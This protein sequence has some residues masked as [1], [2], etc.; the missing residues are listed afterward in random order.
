MIEDEQDPK[1]IWGKI[2]EFRNQTRETNPL[3]VRH[4]MYEAKM[5]SSSAQLFVNQVLSMRSEILRFGGVVSNHEVITIL[6]GGVPHTQVT[7]NFHFTVSKVKTKMLKKSPTDCTLCYV[8]KA[9]L[10]LDSEIQSTFKMKDDASSAQALVNVCAPSNGPN[11]CW[12]CHQQEHFQNQCAEYQEHLLQLVEK[13]REGVAKLN[14]TTSNNVR[15][16]SKSD[17]V[18]LNS[19]TTHSYGNIVEETMKD[20]A[21][22]EF[23]Y[24]SEGQIENDP[25]EDT[26]LESIDEMAMLQAHDDLL[27]EMD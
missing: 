26:T 20:K 16:K 4:R 7:D 12:H 6:I 25:A 18:R 13:V 27:L 8:V 21:K 22:E 1:I 15:A 3:V 19:A 11:K 9:I 23:V 10:T 24:A 14:H 2:L 17:V 5:G